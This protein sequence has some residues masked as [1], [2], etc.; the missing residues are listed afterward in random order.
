MYKFCK[1]CGQVSMNMVCT[2]SGERFMGRC[3][4][5]SDNILDWA[6]KAGKGN[7]RVN[8]ET[9]E[10]GFVAISYKGPMPERRI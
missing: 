1:R 9:D 10:N 3:D 6:E 8:I 2:S 4:K 7:S 5:W